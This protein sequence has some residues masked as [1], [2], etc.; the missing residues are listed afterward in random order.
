[1]EFQTRLYNPAKGREAWLLKADFKTDVDKAL[2]ARANPD[3]FIVIPTAILRKVIN[4][5][6]TANTNSL[7]QQ[8]GRKYKGYTVIQNVNKDQ[9]K[10]DEI[11][12]RPKAV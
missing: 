7:V 1:M 10:I 3:E 11:L 4:Q 8:L 5:E 12:I 9:E 6:T 2:E